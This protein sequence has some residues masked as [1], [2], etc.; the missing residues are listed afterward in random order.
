[1][2]IARLF[3]G[4]MRGWGK[5]NRPEHKGKVMSEFAAQQVRNKIKLF[6]PAFDKGKTAFSRTP[7]PP[8]KDP[9]KVAAQVIS[10]AAGYGSNAL[11]PGE[12]GSRPRPPV[13]P[14]K[15][16]GMAKGSV[17]P[18]PARDPSQAL[19]KANAKSA[20]SSVHNQGLPR[21]GEGDWDELYSG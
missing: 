8:A 19:N 18:P 1:M 4:A 2:S 16:L 15:R 12:V 21:L 10:N 17:P 5:Q 13:P 7:P 14:R 20:R 6:D 11:V 3:S 9:K